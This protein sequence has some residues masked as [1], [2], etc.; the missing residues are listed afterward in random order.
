MVLVSRRRRGLPAAALVS[1]LAA[2]VGSP[3]APPSRGFGGAA[4]APAGTAPLEAQP[5]T[6]TAATAAAVAGVP[7]LGPANDEAAEP[8]DDDREDERTWREALASAPDPT[9][10]A[11]AL[12][13]LLA[14]QERHVEAVAAV[15]VARRRSDAPALLVARAGLL[16]DLGQRHEAVAALR[17]LVAAQGPAAL[18]PALL[19]ELAEL[20]WL[21]GDGAAA[22]ATLRT[23]AAVHAEH[24]WTAQSERE[25]LALAVALARGSRPDQLRVRDLLGNLRG[26]PLVVERLAVLDRLAAGSG[27]DGAAAAAIRERAVAIA[28]GD[29][30]PAVRTRAV[31]LAVPPDRDAAVAFCAAALADDA[32]L[33]RRAAAR[34][35]VDLLGGDGA[36]LL[37]ECMAVEP[38]EHVVR[39]LR[40]ALAQLG[41]AGAEA[42][43]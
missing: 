1:L 6:R 17:A 12:A 38:D 42:G 13:E 8:D 18:H 26:A 24:P 2:C 43:R 5:G 40:E 27:L 10:P 33:V 19:Y 34:R 31:Q 28:A 36:G 22:Q 39:E 7:G 9:G 41:A 16:R 32:P 15:D 30:S 35:V 11:L 14:A 23:L 4:A 37:R 21:E 3:A 20:E 25:R 29:D